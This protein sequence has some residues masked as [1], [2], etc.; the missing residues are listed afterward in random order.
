M[1]VEGQ[2]NVLGVSLNVT[3][4]LYYLNVHIWYYNIN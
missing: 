3:L 2:R 1:T 4:N